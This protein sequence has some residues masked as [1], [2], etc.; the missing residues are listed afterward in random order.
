MLEI[1]HRCVVA[2]W[3][4]YKYCFVLYMY[5]VVFP[6]VVLV[7]QVYSLLQYRERKERLDILVALVP[8]DQL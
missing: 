5:S 3:I 4:N 2:V 1:D 6:I 7:Y 8:P